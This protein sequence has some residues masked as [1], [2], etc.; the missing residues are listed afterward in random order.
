M[1]REGHRMVFYT[2]EDENYLLLDQ[3]S[4]QGLQTRRQRLRAHTDSSGAAGSS[5]ISVDIWD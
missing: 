3:D 4:Y 1:F 5:D 2:Q